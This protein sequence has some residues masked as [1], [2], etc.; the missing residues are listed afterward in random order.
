MTNSL[1]KEKAKAFLDAH[2]NISIPD[3]RE[4]DMDDYNNQKGIN[5]AEYLKEKEN[6]SLEE[7]EKEALKQLKNGDLRV[8]SPRGEVPKWKK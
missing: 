1:G 3:E 7:L 5:A 4:K 8:I 6:F 2:E